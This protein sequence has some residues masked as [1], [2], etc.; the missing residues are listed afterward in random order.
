[1]SHKLP[2][3]AHPKYRPD[4]DGLRAVA[5][6]SV[7]GFHAFPGK[8]P[9]GFIGVDIFFV[10]S[11]FLISTI[12]FSSLERDRFSFVEFYIRRIRRIFPALF[13][14]L[15]ACLAFGWFV[16]L[17]DEYRQLGKHAA[18]GAGFLQ[19]FILYR[20]SGYF[21]LDADTK[22]LLHL[23]S[24][25]VEEQFYIFWPLLLAL[26]W[27]GGWSFLRITFVIAAIS[28]AAN[29][30]LLHRDPTAAFY[31][32]ISRFWELMVGGA[33]AY[34]ALHRPQLNASGKSGQSILGF[35]L[36]ALGF[37]LLNKA[38]EFPGWWALLP[39]L[40]A[41]FIISA[42]PNA[43]L[44]E[45]LLSN[46]VMLWIGMISYPLYLWHW[47]LLSFAQ[48]LQSGNAS[49]GTKLA[50]VALAFLLAWLT[51]LFVEKPLRFGKRKTL[52]TVF[53]LFVMCLF[54]AMGVAITK[55]SF[56][57]RHNDPSL[58][59]IITAINDWEY[60]A[61]FG[62]YVYQGEV[63][64]HV[65]GSSG[66]TT[67]M[68][69]DSHIEQYGPRVLQLSREFPGKL[70]SVYFSTVPA[71]PH[72]PYIHYPQSTECDRSVQTTLEFIKSKHVDDVVIAACWNCYFNKRAYKLKNTPDSDIYSY[73]K[74]GRRENFL[75]GA[76]KDLALQEFEVFLKD[77]SK[78]TKVYLV[79]DNPISPHQDPATW[80]EGDRLSPTLRAN[81]VTP[82]LEIPPEQFALRDKLVRIAGRS[83]V[84][85][86]DPFSILCISEK[87]LCFRT[88]T[89]GKPIYKDSNHL[90]PFFVREHVDYLD[91]A[92]LAR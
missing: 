79:L 71:C 17:A 20:E 7:I 16:L 34:V 50:A 53:L 88:T 86:I 18:A 33:L 30:Y 31:I 83:G 40:G 77:L 12:V 54:L 22:P 29:I 90:R 85:I 13:A 58:A 41:F 81:S 63:F 72:I 62:Q 64:Q 70:N 55:G 21:D 61:H 35:L 28:F 27:K 10:I 89:D 26:V 47:P 48:I 1:M 60:P 15:A 2:H 14:V 84:E 76:G 39:T 57:P 78:I 87:Q 80:V 38:R 46:K 25:A 66:R 51:F 8:F 82:G 92:L 45:K 6:L 49:R 24:L 56:P 65:A 42:G 59:P 73:V 19:N 9:G 74:D 43:W 67:V 69:G 36:I 32:P 3:L 37:L 23:W 5:I 91:R 75:N 11:G 4:I 68:M 44:N 52:I